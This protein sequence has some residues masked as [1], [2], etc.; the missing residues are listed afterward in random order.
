MRSMLGIVLLLLLWLLL[1]LLL[2]K[3]SLGLVDELL[4]RFVA[5]LIVEKGSS[6][7]LVLLL[8][9]LV[10]VV[11]I[12]RESK[13]SVQIITVKRRNLKLTRHRWF[14]LAYFKIADNRVIL[15]MNF[16]NLIGSQIILRSLSVSILGISVCHRFR[17]LFN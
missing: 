8:L 3:I 14:N 6:N 15:R 7:L 5:Y 10:I 1:L 13:R 2:L 17:C 16:V 12:G 11:N 4:R 9:Q